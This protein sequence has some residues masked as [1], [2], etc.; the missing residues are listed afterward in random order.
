MFSGGM[1]VS[2]FQGAPRIW[3]LQ[4]SDEPLDANVDIFSMTLYEVGTNNPVL[5][6]VNLK[7][8]ECF[9]SDHFSSCDLDERGARR[10]KLKTL[11][12]GL[13]VEET[14]VYGCNLTCLRAKA[15][16][17]VIAWTYVISAK[18]QSS[19]ICVCSPC[20]FVCFCG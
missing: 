5:A 13:R 3:Q 9:T 6:S 19:C 4:C 15:F 8:R 20:L 17:G 7:T 18:G 11:I 12:I 10:S 16:G 2:S 14:R 1:T